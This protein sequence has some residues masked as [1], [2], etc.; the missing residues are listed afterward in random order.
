MK[1]SSMKPRRS[2]K[3]TIWEPEAFPISWRI[4]ILSVLMMGVYHRKEGR[5]R[6]P[7]LESGPVNAVYSAMRSPSGWKK[8]GETGTLIF[9][10]RL[11]AH[12][13]KIADLA[14]VQRKKLLQRKRTS[15]C[16]AIYLSSCYQE[17]V[18]FPLRNRNCRNIS[19][20][21]WQEWRT[22]NF[23]RVTVSESRNNILLY[24]C[25]NLCVY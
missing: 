16:T 23:P 14:S 4:K 10:H 21:R 22:G 25:Y 3:S 15:E 11:S 6:R 2:I 24:S 5:S 7:A 9:V 20:L 17:I 1:P 19:T 18:A 12:S 8:R 13:I